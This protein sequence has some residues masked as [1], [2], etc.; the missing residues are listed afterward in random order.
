MTE[1]ELRKKYGTTIHVFDE[2]A[3]RL[4]QLAKTA[5]ID[6]NMTAEELRRKFGSGEEDAAK[7]KELESKL[8]N[9]EHLTEQQRLVLQRDLKAAKASREAKDAA[10]EA[11][12]AA[13]RSGGA[14]ID[15]LTDDEKAKLMVEK[16]EEA[17][18][19]VATRQ[20]AQ[21]V[22]AEQEM[23]AALAA[24]KARRQQ[25]QQDSLQRMQHGKVANEEL[26]A[27]EAML[28]EFQ[29]EALKDGKIDAD[30]QEAIDALRA[31]V[32][33]MQEA[34]ADGL[35]TADELER[36][37]VAKKEG[38]RLAAGASSGGL[39]STTDVTAST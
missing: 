17:L 31:A 24:R 16:H 4:A 20:A 33:A 37:A 1:E 21:K 5:G 39:Y 29:E 30:E 10:A 23:A 35:V 2:E 11:F 36:I 25:R 34:A 28:K 8:K 18:K 3:A 15:S 12:A 6:G 19:S 38:L 13:Q 14:D 26:P 22:E 27:M 7:I 9:E 32:T